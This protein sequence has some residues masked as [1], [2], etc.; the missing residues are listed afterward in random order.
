MW[1]ARLK[2]MA[3]SWFLLSSYQVVMLCIYVPLAHRN[4]NL[5]MGIAF[6]VTCFSEGAKKDILQDKTSMILKVHGHKFHL[7]GKQTPWE[8]ILLLK[9][10]NNLYCFGPKYLIRGYLQRKDKYVSPQVSE[11]EDLMSDT[12]HVND[13]LLFFFYKMKQNDS[14]V[15]SNS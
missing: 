8:N 1:K 10:Y 6:F 14:S 15:N 11:N 9:L 13:I 2:E 12:L 5:D 4:P 3:P 7:V